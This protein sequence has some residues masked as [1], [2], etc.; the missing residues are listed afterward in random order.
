MLAL[1][2]LQLAVSAPVGDANLA[3][4]KRLAQ[5]GR[6]DYDAGRFEKAI[7]EFLAADALRPVPALAYNVA[8]AYEK[9]GRND[10]AVVYLRK[11][12]E[13]A[14]A[15]PDRAAV[16]ATIKNLLAETG[17]PVVVVTT[18]GESPPVEKPAPPPAP[19]AAVEKA[20]AEAPAGHSHAVGIALTVTGVVAAGLAVVGLVNVVNYNSLS[21]QVQSGGYSGS[22]T[23][24][25]GSRSSAENWGSVGIACVV[26]AVGAGIGAA[27]TW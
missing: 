15:A 8:Q 6:R 27:V 20:P 5:Q 4:A 19:A 2:V 25:T 12:L 9:L 26:L 18:G 1:L 23:N 21:S 14:P 22:W 24:V 16:E 13:E 7:A 17:S 11:Y 3:E 10:K